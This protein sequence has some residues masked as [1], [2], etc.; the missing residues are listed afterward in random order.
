M[1]DA[2]GGGGGGGGGEVVFLGGV[3]RYQSELPVDQRVV[4]EGDSGAFALLLR[5]LHFH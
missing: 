5:M 2:A 4:D 3:S 1:G